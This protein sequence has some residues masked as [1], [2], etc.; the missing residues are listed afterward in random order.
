MNYNKV[1]FPI[2]IF[3][4]EAEI[5]PNVF[6]VHSYSTF[7]FS[8]LRCILAA[9]CHSYK[10]SVVVCNSVAS[11]FILQQAYLSIELVR[12]KTL[13][14]INVFMA[15][16]CFFFNVR[17]FMCQELFKRRN[18][19][20]SIYLSIPQCLYAYLYLLSLYIS[21]CIYLYYSPIYIFHFLISKIYI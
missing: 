14:W 10:P 7:Q 18:V 9:C 6:F 3:D 8:R 13:I 1:F 2:I 11:P 16:K 20:Q 15:L 17:K 21:I 5:S 19:S 4:E 12:E